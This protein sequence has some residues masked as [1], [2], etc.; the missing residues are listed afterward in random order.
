MHAVTKPIT[1]L[2]SLSKVG[3]LAIL[4]LN[5]ILGLGIVVFPFPCSIATNATIYIYTAT[6]YSSH[7][8]IEVIFVLESYF[9]SYCKLEVYHIL[10]SL[11]AHPS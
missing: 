2:V 7:C 3:G 9:N 6:I 8:L 11:K 5:L 1:L 10:S 4:L